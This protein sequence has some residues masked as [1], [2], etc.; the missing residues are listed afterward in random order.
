[1]LS[2]KNISFPDRPLSGLPVQ[3]KTVVRD[4]ICSAAQPKLDCK[5]VRIVSVVS[6]T[7][8]RFVKRKFGGSEEME[9]DTVERR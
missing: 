3:Q 2:L 6:R 5:T 1:M 8:D 7:N 9:T 4:V